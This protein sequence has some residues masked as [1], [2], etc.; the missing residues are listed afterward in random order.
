[1]VRQRGVDSDFFAA[2]LL[3]DT[4]GELGFIKIGASQRTGEEP[5]NET[6][7]VVLGLT[8]A[9]DQHLAF[10]LR[11]QALTQKRGTSQEFR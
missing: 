2:Q 3:R 5:E 6:M 1:M 7:F 10:V 11:Q 9:G 8:D 4:L